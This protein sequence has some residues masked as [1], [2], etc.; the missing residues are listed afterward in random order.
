MGRRAEK[1]DDD[2]LLVDNDLPTAW[3][4]PLDMRESSLFLRLDRQRAAYFA[5]VAHDLDSDEDVASRDGDEDSACLPLSGFADLSTWCCDACLPLPPPPVLLEEQLEKQPARLL[6]LPDQ[7]TVV[8][9]LP[10]HLA[11]MQ[12]IP[13]LPAI[14]A[15]EVCKVC[16]VCEVCEVAHNL[17]AD[18]LRPSTLGKIR[19]KLARFWR[20]FLSVCFRRIKRV[21]QV[22]KVQQPTLTGH[23]LLMERLHER[24]QRGASCGTPP[25]LSAE[26]RARQFRQPLDRLYN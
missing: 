15:R 6:S 7:P 14:S 21:V 19:E 13:I 1:D 2:R 11:D 23:E 9:E 8:L 20:F 22:R 5:D 16:E 25:A 17:S 3:S 12:T 4:P 10:I 24:S 26:Q 18:G